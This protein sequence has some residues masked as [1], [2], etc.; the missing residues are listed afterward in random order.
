M[1]RLYFLNHSKIDVIFNKNSRDFVVEEVSLYE[2]SG[3]GE[4]LVLRVRKKDMTTWDML[5]I[6]S[7]HLGIRVRDI[8]YA[9]LKDKDGMTIQSI[10]M[11][12]K[13][14]EE[15]IKNFSHDKIKILK[16]DYHK[17]KLRIGHLKGNK[18]F[19]RLKKVSKTD[20]TILINILEKIKDTGIPNYFG[21]QRFGR[22]K[23][24]HKMGKEILE[25]KKFERR[26]K[27][28]NFFISAYQSHLF[29]LWLSKRVE[30]SKFFNSFTV[31]E[32]TEM[33]NWSKEIITQV[34][35][36]ENFCKI[37]PGDI[38]H[39][40]P[41][42]KAFLIN[43]IVEEAKR[44]KNQETTLAGLLVGK[45]PIKADGIAGNI[46][47]DFFNECKPFL[48][49]MEGSRRLAWIFPKDI[50]YNYKE[51]Q[52]WL[53]LNFFLPKGSYATVFL[54]ELLHN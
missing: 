22:D 27:M 49:K 34:K 52:A 31:K 10:S 6:M 13:G 50:E 19:I 18:F 28:K 35:N 29:N 46:E 12:K 36:Q 40:Y 16:I 43:E 41:H 51:E 39:H 1:D 30:I 14:V 21:Y 33:F 3:E 11:I 54:E 37:L 38:M 45:K 17:N 48:D 26:K 24:N 5:Q 15:R 8:G 47:R 9:G 2:N 23:V 7:E 25:G 53:E 42:G 20:S 32:L 44:F 4:H